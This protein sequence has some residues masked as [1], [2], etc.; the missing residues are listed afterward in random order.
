MM[1]IT[2]R[3]LYLPVTFLT[4]RYFST[5]GRGVGPVW[6]SRMLCGGNE[7]RLT[8]CPHAGWKTETRR[9]CTDHSRDASVMCYKQGTNPVVFLIIF[10]NLIMVSL[11]NVSSSEILSCFG[12]LNVSDLAVETPF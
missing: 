10:G 2:Y 5:Y 8:E 12:S 4:V 11:C 7:S 9:I 1:H 3:T 6:M